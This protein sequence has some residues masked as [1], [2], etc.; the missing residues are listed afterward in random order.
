MRRGLFLSLLLLNSCGS[1]SLV[2]RGCK[3]DGLWGEDLSYNEH[4]E[5]IIDKSY[6]VWLFDTEVKLKDILRENKIEC[7]EVK[8]LRV[9]IKS[10]FFVKRD[11]KIF[12]EK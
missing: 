12:L 4:K 1:I 5:I 7:S 10:T 9:E 3:T 6:Y 8:K 11:L 2:P